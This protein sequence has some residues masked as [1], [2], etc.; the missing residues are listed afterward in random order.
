MA[1]TL[2]GVAYLFGVSATS[3]TASQII[4]F[5]LGK[6]DA[7]EN[8]IS[9]S[10]GAVVTV[11]SDDE[12]GALDLEVKITTNFVEVAIASNMTVVDTA[13]VNIA[14]SYMVKTATLSGQNK[15]FKTYKIT[16]VKREYLALS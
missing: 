11:R 5:S 8:E 4:S 9:D 3:P 15:D 7:N 13:N 6:S 12:R 1:A 14:G 16:A 10:T 2:Y